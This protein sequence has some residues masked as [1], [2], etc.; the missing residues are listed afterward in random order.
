VNDLQA[1]VIAVLGNALR[2]DGVTPGYMHPDS[3]LDALDGYAAMT[4]RTVYV[5]LVPLTAGVEYGFRR[6]GSTY[7][8]SVSA[9]LARSLARH[10]AA[11][12]CVLLERAVWPWVPAVLPEGD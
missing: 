11:D 9:A 12:T 1:R 4:G 5:S 10:S 7:V 6:H 8:A 2:E 3:A